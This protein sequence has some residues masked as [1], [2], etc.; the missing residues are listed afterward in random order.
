MKGMKK[1]NPC[2]RQLGVM[3]LWSRSLVDPL[4]GS[5][6]ILDLCVRKDE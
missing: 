6:I 5:L 4:L 2:G 1:S 3:I